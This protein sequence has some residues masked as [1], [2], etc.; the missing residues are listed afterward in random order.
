MSLLSGLTP[1]DNKPQCPVVRVA[2]KLSKED[3]QILLDSLDN[4]AWSLNALWK[5]LKRRGLTLSRAA[6]SAHRANECAC[7]A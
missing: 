3:K 2:G 4:P 6:M 5:E 7:N 1:P